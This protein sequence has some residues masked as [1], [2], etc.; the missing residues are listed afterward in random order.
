M[1]GNDTA[2][3]VRAGRGSLG[4]STAD[5]ERIARALRERL[6]NGSDE[7]SG[8]ALV[9]TNVASGLARKGLALVGT[10]LAV[11]GALVALSHVNLPASVAAAPAPA[12]F[13]VPAIASEAAKSAPT[14]A[15]DPVA[16]ATLVETRAPEPRGAGARRSS[17]RLAEEIAILS[18]AETELHAG[19]PASA[20]EVLGEHRRKFPN[21]VL[22]QERIAARIHA[23]C[24]LGRTSEAESELARLERL[25][26]GSPQEDRA[27]E[28]CAPR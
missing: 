8:G 28:A 21:G 27:R 6:G 5:R 15:V 17:D 19:R 12:V 9:L 2:A 7:T 16:P 1:A 25:S 11:G 26:P 18:R 4:P 20:L 10:M 23:L 14:P 22:A 24:A 3:L 13:K